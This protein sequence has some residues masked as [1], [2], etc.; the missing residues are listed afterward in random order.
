MYS[1]GKYSKNADKLEID[2]SKL[3]SNL[4]FYRR[5]PSSW[6]CRILRREAMP[7]DH[8]MTVKSTWNK[9]TWWTNS[10]KFNLG[11]RL[12]NT[13]NTEWILIK[14]LWI[15]TLVPQ[16]RTVKLFRT[17]MLMKTVSN[18]V[19]VINLISSSQKEMILVGEVYNRN[20][21]S[22]WQYHINNRKQNTTKNSFSKCISSSKNNHNSRIFSKIKR[23][24][25]NI[26]EIQVIKEELIAQR[27]VNRS[28]RQL[29]QVE[30][31]VQ[32]CVRCHR[33]RQILRC[34][35]RPWLNSRKINHNSSKNGSLGHSA[36]RTSA[37][38]LL[39]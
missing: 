10:Q 25:N 23:K 2:V 18:I 19:G 4:I 39:F 24:I 12:P 14:R 26:I 27:M 22:P 30:V 29:L 17:I 31:L 8:K 32:L 36:S 34:K 6:E 28:K 11:Q 16:N 3:I 38:K 37:V 9:A 33:G 15:G 35:L 20:K 21:S 1:K 5:S 7:A 13:S